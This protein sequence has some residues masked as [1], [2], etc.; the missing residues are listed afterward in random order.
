MPDFPEAS[1][2]PVF[3]ALLPVESFFEETSPSEFPPAASF[4][5]ELSTFT[6]TLLLFSGRLSVSAGYAVYKARKKD[7]RDE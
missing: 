4:L 7:S 2:V 5:L 3:S 1:D 6:T